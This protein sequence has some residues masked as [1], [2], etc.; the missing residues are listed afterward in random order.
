[1]ERAPSPERVARLVTRLVDRD[2]KLPS[3]L[4]VGSIFQARIA[5]FL[6][7]VSPLAW[8]RYVLEKYYKLKCGCS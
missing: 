4:N 2:G 6:N 1:M 8:T 5:P 3:R 7:G